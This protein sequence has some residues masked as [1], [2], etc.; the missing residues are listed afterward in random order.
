MYKQ[1]E[2]PWG[3]IYLN[4]SQFVNLLHIIHIFTKSY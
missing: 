3:Y 2:I 4:Y 1:Q